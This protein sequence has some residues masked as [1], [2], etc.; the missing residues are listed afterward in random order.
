MTHRLEIVLVCQLAL[1]T[2]SW[3]SVEA[4][5]DAN[6]DSGAEQIAPQQQSDF[7]LP[8]LDS[9]PPMLSSKQR[10]VLRKDG[11]EPQFSMRTQRYH[12]AFVE[13]EPEIL[14]ITYP[15]YHG[16]FPRS[17][18][19]NVIL[20]GAII[21]DPRH[22]ILLPEGRP[23]KE[24]EPVI[25][26]SFRVMERYLHRN[27]SKLPIIKSRK[28]RSSGRF[29]P[30]PNGKEK[31]SS[32]TFVASKVRQSPPGTQNSSAQPRQERMISKT[33]PNSTE[34]QEENTRSQAVPEAFSLILPNGS[35]ADPLRLSSGL[36]SSTNDTVPYLVE[37]I[38]PNTSDPE[39]NS[40]LKR[41][42]RFWLVPL[43]GHRRRREALPFY[44]K[45]TFVGG[46]DNGPPDNKTLLTMFAKASEAVLQEFQSQ[47]AKHHEFRDTSDVANKYPGDL[48]N[49]VVDKTGKKKNEAL[50]G[51]SSGNDTLGETLHAVYENVKGEDERRFGAIDLEELKGEK[52]PS[53]KE[54]ESERT[55]HQHGDK[56]KPHTKHK[57]S[58]KKR[59][60]GGGRRPPQTSTDDQGQYD[61]TTE[62]DSA[63][64]DTDQE[65]DDT[66]T[67]YPDDSSGSSNRAGQ[68]SR[69]GFRGQQ[70]MLPDSRWRQNAD[71]FRQANEMMDIS[72]AYGQQGYPRGLLQQRDLKQRKDFL[73]IPDF[74]PVVDAYETEKDG[75]LVSV[76]G[77]PYVLIKD[78]E[79]LR[80][81]EGKRPNLE[82][83]PKADAG[84]VPA[85]NPLAHLG[86]VYRA[87]NGQ[88]VD[89][90]FL[91]SLQAEAVITPDPAN[92]K[93]GSLEDYPLALLFRVP[94]QKLVRSM[95]VP[96]KR[97]QGSSGQ[98]SPM[99]FKKRSARWYNR[100]KD[101]SGLV[102]SKDDNCVQV[103]NSV[104]C[105]HHRRV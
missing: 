72:Y 49:F 25:W 32:E 55:S 90:N 75:Q 4:S 42:K 63:G 93:K 3:Q 70:D 73:N 59:H 99:P 94:T 66:S 95:S 79:A 44:G 81:E 7:L 92:V 87:L 15:D 56:E 85:S 20:P 26:D 29:P 38:G 53:H 54:E 60:R 48:F 46:H 47:D 100:R 64:Q 16:L 14:Q 33:E 30:I 78:P 97:Q 77:A 57:V 61:D 34:Q 84:E 9:F 82:E 52:T 65:T 37:V 91:N 96:Q 105:Y 18:K 50:M 39:Q 62:S 89:L 1:F 2:A 51:Q 76:N 101:D 45:A 13:P 27:E 40:K 67:D 31:R 69:R 10:Q 35:S 80:N 19:P 5:G 83:E 8:V 24:L 28:R 98:P 22:G 103:K 88:K 71:A 74:G 43:Q 102:R 104:V 17:T 58:L 41:V 21:V 86:M 23:R 36:N 12:N 6:V 11:P 68:S